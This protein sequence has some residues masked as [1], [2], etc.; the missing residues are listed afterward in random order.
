MKEGSVRRRNGGGE[1]CSGERTSNRHLQVIQ[2]LKGKRGL[3]GGTRESFEKELEFG[4]GF[5]CR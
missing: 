1:G 3:D 4:L 5:S 2:I